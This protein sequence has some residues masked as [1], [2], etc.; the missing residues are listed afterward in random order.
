MR[1]L[2]RAGVLAAALSTVAAS[3]ALAASSIQI[4]AAFARVITR[5]TYTSLCDAGTADECGVLDLAGLGLADYEYTYGPTF[6]PTGDLGCF[7]IDGTFSLRL[8]SDGSWISGALTGVFC[9]PGASAHQLGTGSWGNPRAEQDTVAFSGGT[10]QFAGLEGSV[11]FAERS[12][13]ARLVGSLSGEL[14]D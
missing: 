7:A 1:Q 14:Q 10:G 5:P 12:A 2:L 4:D 11:T 13:G 3:G 6:E 8:L 9:T